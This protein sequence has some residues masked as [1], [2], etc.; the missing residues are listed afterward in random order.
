[1]QKIRSRKTR[2]VLRDRHRDVFLTLTARNLDPAHITKLLGVKPDASWKRGIEKDIHG[3]VIKDRYGNPRKV[4]FG[5]WQLFPHVH[6]S[7]GFEA[8]LTNL[9]QII[10]P[11]KY[12]LRRLLA[13]VKGTLDIVVE[14][15]LDVCVR[16]IVLP[17]TILNKFT[18]LG[19]DI[20]ITFDDPHN[21][22]KFW[23]KVAKRGISTR[24]KGSKVQKI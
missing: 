12:R 2:K 17:A 18:S 9:L 4:R 8:R 21:W 1:M 6:E 22:D 24:T 15:H 20:E 3:N 5:G 10:T 7:S 23:E 11:C 14:P 13:T 19:I 16:T